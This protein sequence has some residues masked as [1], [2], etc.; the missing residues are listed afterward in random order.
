MVETYRYHFKYIDF[1]QK[2]LLPNDDVFLSFKVMWLKIRKKYQ[3]KCDLCIWYIYVISN[4][5]PKIVNLIYV[6]VV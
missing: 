1:C 4:T 6:C 5:K 3:N 2:N